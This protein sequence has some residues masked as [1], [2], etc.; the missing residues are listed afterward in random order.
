LTSGKSAGRS[1][2][3]FAVS[4]RLMRRILV[5]FARSRRYQKRDTVMR[6]WKLAKV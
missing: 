6:D 1:A 4:A 2:H 5:D 3:F